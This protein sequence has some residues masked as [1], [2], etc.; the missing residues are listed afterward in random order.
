MQNMGTGGLEF[1]GN[2]AGERDVPRG[3]ETHTNNYYWTTTLRPR[4]DNQ[5]QG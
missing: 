5:N 4:G 1:F 3:T 2:R